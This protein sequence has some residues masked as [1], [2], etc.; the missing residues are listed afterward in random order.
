MDFLSLAQRRQSCRNFDPSREVESEKLETILA[1]ALLAPSA[2]NRQP[3]EIFVAKGEKAKKIALETQD[4]GINL[5]TT[6]AS[7]MLVIS[8]K[9]FL[10]NGK[11]NLFSS[12]DVGILASHICFQAEEL[13]LATCMIGYFREENVRVLCGA[14]DKIRLIVALGYA[15]PADPIRTKKRKEKEQLIQYI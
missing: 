15:N 2:K 6:D 12:I 3:Y 4:P 10:E 11:E 5:F 14:K 13:G 9:P 8:E 1:A 7:V